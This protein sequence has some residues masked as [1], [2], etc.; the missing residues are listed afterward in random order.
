VER[1]RSNFEDVYVQGFNTEAI[2]GLQHIIEVL[3]ITLEALKRGIMSANRPELDLL[4]RISCTTQ[5]SKAIIHAGIKSE[6]RTCY[7]MFSRN[8]RELIKARNNALQSLSSFDFPESIVEPSRRDTLAAKLGLKA[9]AYFI[10][11]DSEFLKYL[12]ER[13]ALVT[14]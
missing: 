14:R 8:K 5:I 4:L 11:D 7:V 1:I 6:K 3:K 2:F 9:G 13:A 12:I 10:T